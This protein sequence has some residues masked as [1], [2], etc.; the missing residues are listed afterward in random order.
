MDKLNRTTLSRAVAGRP[1]KAAQAR[2]KVSR[3]TAKTPVKATRA[4]RPGRAAAAIESFLAAR[5]RG[6]NPS[7]PQKTRRPAKG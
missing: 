7:F 5:E 1:S 4:F 2:D 3:P 6:E